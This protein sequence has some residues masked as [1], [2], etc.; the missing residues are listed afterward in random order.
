[1]PDLDFMAPEFATED[2]DV[3]RLVTKQIS[4][5]L[6]FLN[7]WSIFCSPAVDM[8]TLGM[9][10]FTLYNSKPLFTNSGS[11]S[12]FKRNASEVFYK[13]LIQL[14]EIFISF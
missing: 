14:L 9:L 13:I 4:L 10:A 7:T 5:N 8:F 1:M 12:T 6:Q 2:D 11:W 3:L